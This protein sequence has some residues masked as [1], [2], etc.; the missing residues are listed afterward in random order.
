M[1]VI[2]DIR[3][4]VAHCLELDQDHVD[5]VD[6]RRSALSINA[7][8]VEEGVVMSG[9]GTL[10]LPRFTSVFGLCW[11]TTTCIGCMGAVMDLEI[12]QQQTERLILLHGRI[13]AEATERLLNGKALSP[14]EEQGVLHSLQVVIENS[15]GKAKHYLK[16]LGLKVPVRCL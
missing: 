13:L 14:M 8:I 12:Y 11:R 9:D 7:S 3:S 1:G 15:I 5:L 10:E 2:E 16:H 4:A 6:L